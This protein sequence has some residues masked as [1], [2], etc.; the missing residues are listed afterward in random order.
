V[1]FY[2]SRYSWNQVGE[3]VMGDPVEGTTDW[4]YFSADCVA[5][6]ETNYLNVRCNLDPP[7]DG[8]GYAWFDDLR[9][10][11]WLDWQPLTLPMDVPFPNNFRFV[12]LRV[13]GTAEQVTVVY[14][15]TK[16]TDGGFSSV[17]ED[18]EAV[19]RINVLLRGAAPNPIRTHTTL[20]YRLSGRAKVSLNIYDPAGRLVETLV[21][22]TWQRPGW[23][24]VQWQAS[25]VSAGIYFSNL[26]VGEEI[27]SK[28]MVVVR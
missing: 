26:K 2:G 4:T 15:E 24:R 14:E 22:Q 13:P 25:D 10:V 3:G 28:K 19:A 5:P 12:Q 8:D 6:E 27:H 20:S 21:D 23:H 7:Q 18:E 9:V 1:R 17:P 11:E 16:L